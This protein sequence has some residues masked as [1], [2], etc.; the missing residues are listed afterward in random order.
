M[1]GFSVTYAHLEIRQQER[2]VI[3]QRSRKGKA[4]LHEDWVLDAN[5]TVQRKMSCGGGTKQSRRPTAY[6]EITNCDV[7]LIF[8]LVLL[9][10]GI[11]SGKA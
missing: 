3:W 4:E 10:N 9:T 7:L 8:R 5:S 1:V 11:F 2:S 6:C